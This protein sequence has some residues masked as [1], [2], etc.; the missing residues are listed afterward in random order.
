ML[1]NRPPGTHSCFTTRTVW[2]HPVLQ[3][4][5]LGGSFCWY[6]F[7]FCNSDCWESFCWDYFLVGLF[8]VMQPRL[9]GIILLVCDSF[10]WDSFCSDCLCW[11]YFLLGLFPSPHGGLSELQGQGICMGQSLR[12]RIQILRYPAWL[13]QGI[14]TF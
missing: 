10:H 9:L 7:L 12:R 5:Q 8:P 14:R 11:D 2:T 1:L 6:S 13:R 3:L 4:R